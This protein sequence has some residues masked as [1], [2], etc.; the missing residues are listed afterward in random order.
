MLSSLHLLYWKKDMWQKEQSKLFHALHQFLQLVRQAIP[1]YDYD[2][3]SVCVCCFV[4]WFL[5]N[6]NFISTNQEEVTPL[7]VHITLEQIRECLIYFPSTRLCTFFPQFWSGLDELWYSS[8]F[9]YYTGHPPHPPPQ[10][11]MIVCF[12]MNWVCHLFIYHCHESMT[13]TLSLFAKD[14]HNNYINMK[15]LIYLYTSILGL[16]AEI[17]DVRAEGGM[18]SRD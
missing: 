4:L 14:F 8:A 6:Q 11:K 9:E 17:K 16:L 13:H 5:M 10:S 12:T 18:C 3:E 7:K 1:W 2:T 15:Y